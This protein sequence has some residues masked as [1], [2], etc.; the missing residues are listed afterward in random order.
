MSLSEL[1]EEL[2]KRGSSTQGRK[3]ILIEWLELLLF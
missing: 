2:S 3:N 1:K